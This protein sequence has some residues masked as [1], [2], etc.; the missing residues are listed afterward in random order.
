[1]GFHE[2]SLGFLCPLVVWGL[3]GPSD[4]GPWSVPTQRLK[5]DVTLDLVWVLERLGQ[6]PTQ[7]GGW[8]T[9]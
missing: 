8:G 3:P 6:R 7:G 2:I 5:V 4:T 1:M 9:Q